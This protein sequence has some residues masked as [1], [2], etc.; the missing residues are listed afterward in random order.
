M[1]LTVLLLFFC[2]PQL[3]LW[4]DSDNWETATVPS[5][6]SYVII[7]PQTVSSRV[8][9]A[10]KVDITSLTISSNVVLLFTNNSTL[11]VSEQFSIIN[12]CTLSSDHTSPLSFSSV[13]SL[14]LDSVDL[15]TFSS[16][17]LIVTGLFDWKR[18]S[19][20]LHGFS[21]LV[22][23]NS[24]SA[25]HFTSHSPLSSDLLHVWGFNPEGHLGGGLQESSDGISPESYTLPDSIRQASLGRIHSMILLIN[26]DVYTA[27]SNTFGELGFNGGGRNIHGKIDLSHII[28]II[29]SSESSY[30]LSVSGSVYSWG[31]NRNGQLGIGDRLIRHTPTLIPNLSN[32]K[33]IAGRYLTV[34][35]LTRNDEVYG[36][37][38]GANN[39]LCSDST[40]NVLSPLLIES[41]Q[42]IKFVAAGLS[43]FFVKSNG[44]TL[45]CG[46]RLGETGFYSTPTPF[47]KDIEFTFIDTIYLHALGIDVNQKLWSW[48]SNSLGQLGTGGNAASASPVQVTNIGKVITSAAGWGHS[49]AVD[50]SN[51]VWSWGYPEEVLGRSFPPNLN[52]SN[53]GLIPGLSP[54]ISGISAY[55]GSNFAYSSVSV[56]VNSV[57]SSSSNSKMIL[58]GNNDIL[59]KVNDNGL[60]QFNLISVP[61]FLSGSL[62]LTSDS[63][64]FL[65]EFNL[66]GLLSINSLVETYF[67][68]FFLGASECSTLSLE[69]NVFVETL[70][71]YCG[72]IEGVGELTVN[73][74][75]FCSSNPE[76]K[77][78]RISIGKMMTSELNVEFNLTTDLLISINGIL[79]ISQV[80]FYSDSDVTVTFGGNLKLVN[81]SL[82]LHIDSR[83]NS[84]IQ[85]DQNSKIQITSSSSSLGS[86][87]PLFLYYD[88]SESPS[89]DDLSGN[90][91]NVLE[92]SGAQWNPDGY[93]QFEIATNVIKVPNI[94]GKFGWASATISFSIWFDSDSTNRFGFITNPSGCGLVLGDHLSFGDKTMKD[95][96]IP[97]NQWISLIVTTDHNGAQMYVNG[98]LI[99]SVNGKYG[100]D[101]FSDFF[102]LGS[103][104]YKSG[105]DWVGSSDQFFK[106]RI[107]RVAVFTEKLSE[108][109]VEALS[110]TQLVSLTQIFGDGS[111]V[112]ENSS[113]RVNSLS[114]L[115]LNSLYSYNSSLF[116]VPSAFFGVVNTVAKEDS[117]IEIHGRFLSSDFFLPNLELESSSFIST[118]LELHFDVISFLNSDFSCD[119]YLEALVVYWF[120]G[121]LTLSEAKVNVIN[122]YGNEKVL[123]IESLTITEEV[124]FNNSLTLHSNNSQ[125]ILDSVIV[126]CTALSSLFLSCSSDC[127]S[128]ELKFSNA[129][130]LSEYCSFVSNFDISNCALFKSVFT[131]HNVLQIDE[132][133]EFSVVSSEFSIESVIDSSDP[134]LF[135]Y[136]NWAY[137]LNKIDLSGNHGL[138]AIIIHGPVW[139]SD[140]NGG[141]LKITPGNTLLI[142]NLPGATGWTGTTISLW[143][144][145]QAGGLGL[146][147]GGSCRL[148]IEPKRVC[149]GT[150]CSTVHFPTTW[151]HLAIKF[152]PFD[153]L[154]TMPR[155]FIDGS[156]RNSIGAGHG[157]H[158]TNPPS[159][160]S[161]SRIHPSG[162]QFRGMIRAVQ[163]FRRILSAQEIAN[164]ELS[165]PAGVWGQGKFSF[166]NSHC[167]LSSM[168]FEIRYMSLNSSFFQSGA[169]MLRHLEEL[170]LSSNSE[171]VFVHS[172]DFDFDSTGLVV[173]LD[174]SKLRYEVIDSATK[175]L[176]DS[177]YLTNT[178]SIITDASLVISTF[179]WFQGALFSPGVTSLQRLFLYG[180]SKTWVADSLIIENELYFNNSLSF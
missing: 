57:G 22:L 155:V 31:R 23:V 115:S 20:D 36:W 83:L 38:A 178:S 18:G 45:T 144:N 16:H 4:F 76:L 143:M 147:F 14:E 24:T 11:T 48:G 142:P 60:Q 27:G 33:Q 74:L 84:N 47:A 134:S 151:F 55:H 126:K 65:S 52:E 1:F 41:L 100:C 96:S 58:K 92:V 111:M 21:E 108:S 109:E 64:Y 168:Y 172:H 104:Y 72:T 78:S 122:L 129:F 117:T 124:F 174:S 118:T 69:S 156:Y 67:T 102:P 77:L 169:V 141:Y 7:P 2:L 70:Y 177:I 136:Y 128:A 43:S 161:L 25:S 121:I 137:S 110:K 89:G 154:R 40:S 54:I 116:I 10:S 19:I 135:M 82:T 6:S 9:I 12:G 162:S 81:T 146:D 61:V 173:F 171:I 62:N 99:A 131:S 163:V 176:I 133:A 88:W 148:T 180:D 35:A 120:D 145:I 160:F 73:T 68:S 90:N 98:A 50:V 37:G 94:S 53:P 71:C 159:H 29:S 138:S 113:F 179:H 165:F 28:Q 51:D 85:F 101:E 132:H 119:C 80:T 44:S 5:S 157:Y 140:D 150:L 79:K 13:K 107:R 91:N 153:S 130:V 125:L 175:V 15:V 139:E 106:G 97:R 59:G 170:D 86:V 127:T 152:S 167:V 39:V 49:I 95:L 123:L 3:G 56:V 26:G 17:K 105:N 87:Y 166:I 114:T 93:Y 8:V 66:S 149:W 30:A 75:V 158:C 32:I 34:F 63:F 42:N 112:I 46:L 103:V 164:L